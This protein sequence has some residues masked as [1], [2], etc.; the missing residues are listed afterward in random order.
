MNV[1]SAIG[2]YVSCSV[3]E[4]DAC[5]RQLL[6]LLSPTLPT[7]T[8][9]IYHRRQAGTEQSDASACLLYVGPGPRLVVLQL[10][11]PCAVVR[12]RC[13]CRRFRRQLHAGLGPDRRQGQSQCQPTRLKTRTR[14]GSRFPAG[15]T[16]SWRQL[17]F[18]L[19][20]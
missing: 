2:T 4:T 16:V 1:A 13:D 10:W 11:V 19:Y 15:S 6:T 3:S 9:P 17:S 12:R 14:Y 7:T 5:R 8:G 20:K 18:L